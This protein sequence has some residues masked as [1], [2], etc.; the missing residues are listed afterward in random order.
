MSLPSIQATVYARNRLIIDELDY[1]TNLEI[2]KFESLVRGLSSHHYHV[3]KSV[4]DTY[5]GG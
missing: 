3:F 1:D 5:K 4:L 2:S